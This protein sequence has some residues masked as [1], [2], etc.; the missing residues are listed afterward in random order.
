MYVPRETI[1]HLKYIKDKDSKFHQAIQNILDIINPYGHE[2]REM[3][4][5]ENKLFDNSEIALNELE[6]WKNKSK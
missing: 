4:E 5:E 1:E 6:K 2:D 3:S